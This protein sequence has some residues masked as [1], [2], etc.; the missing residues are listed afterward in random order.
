M[1][2]EVPNQLYSLDIEPSG[3]LICTGGY[4]PYE[5]YVFSL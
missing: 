5:I 4:D 1:K 3:D 2:P